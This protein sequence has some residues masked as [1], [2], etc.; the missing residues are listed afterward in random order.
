MTHR[1]PEGKGL[2][3]WSLPHSASGNPF[4][5]AQKARESGYRWL[6]IKV[7]DG[8]RL[9][10]PDITPQ[11]VVELKKAGIEV[12]GWA[13]LRGGTLWGSSI[14]RQEADVTIEAHRRYDLEGFII[15]A[16]WEYKRAGAAIWARDYGTRV[17]G[18]Y[19][20]FSM[21]LCSYRF[22]SYHRALPFSQFMRYC[23]FH[24]PQV[25]WEG[26]HNPGYQLERSVAELLQIEL[27]PV[28][29]IGSAYRR[30]TWEPTLRDFTEF[31][32]TAKELNLTGFGYWSWQHLEARPE[33]WNHIAGQ[34]IGAPVTPPPPPPPPEVGVSKWQLNPV[35]YLLNVREE[36][37]I[38]GS[39]PRIVNTIRRG[40]VVTVRN[41]MI[42]SWGYVVEKSGWANTNFMDELDV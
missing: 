31:R 28:I 39:P 29:P 41:E 11:F 12:W 23:D 22:P 27:A 40:E 10:N 24:M 33:W 2:F 25:Y 5:M 6:A 30:G 36:P 19:P 35:T 4:L 8:L 7:Q 42:G 15:D 13:Y 38:E 17:K 37:W 16:E 32:D 3:V 1:S 9:Y 20:D 21:G 14:A 26:S 34:T 18:L